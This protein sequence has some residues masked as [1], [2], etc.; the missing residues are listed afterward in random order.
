[1]L[2]ITDKGKSGKIYGQEP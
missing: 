1:M 2:E